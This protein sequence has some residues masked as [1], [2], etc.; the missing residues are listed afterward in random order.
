MARGTRR[1]GEEA[2][3]REIMA[4]L[5]DNPGATMAEVAT[6]TGVGRTTIYRH[7]SDRE[8][9][10]DRVALLGASLYIEAFDNARPREG[11]GLQ[12]IERFCERLFEIPDVLS[13][14]FADTPLITDDS[15]AR[16]ERLTRDGTEHETPGKGRKSK[17]PDDTEG[18]LSTKGSTGEN[19]TDTAPPDPVAAVIERGR[20]DGSITTDVPTTWASVFVVLTVASGHLYE[21]MRDSTGK[22]ECRE[23]S[24]LELTLRAIRSTLGE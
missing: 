5:A 6:A 21:S 20:N 4:V 18:P 15:F 14:L 16:L 17:S 2:L 19:T 8:T 23:P 3:L 11:T 7:F 10:V 9:M 13:L 22:D 1:R 24:G 12:A